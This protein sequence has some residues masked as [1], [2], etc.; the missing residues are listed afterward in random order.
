MTN[1]YNESAAEV[2]N[3]MDAVYVKKEDLHDFGYLDSNLKL[4][5][6]KIGSVTLTASDNEIGV[7]DTITLTATVKDIDN[8]N[9]AD[10]PVEFYKGNTL[11]ETSYTNNN[12]VA[13]YTETGVE[14]NSS[15]NANIGNK[16]SNNI[17]IKITNPH[18]GQLIAFYEG[19]DNTNASDW[20]FASSPTYSENGTQ[21]NG[22]AAYCN[23]NLEGGTI[24]TAHIKKITPPKIIEIDITNTVGSPYVN[25]YE[26][27]QLRQINFTL[28]NGHYEF[29][30]INNKCTILKDDVIAYDTS[31]SIGDFTFS[32]NVLGSKF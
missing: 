2:A 8:N 23:P 3:A 24:G 12:G 7:G 6:V 11:L 20:Y 32:I 22:D 17:N 30:L 13:T 19:I 31:G 5:L 27:S 15:Y 26:Q 9:V 29:V 21:I 4:H 25:I 1:N 10:A 16:T 14:S 18:K 28:S